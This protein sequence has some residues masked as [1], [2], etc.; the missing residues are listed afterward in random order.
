ME[1]N[2]TDVCRLTSCM[3]ITDEKRSKRGGGG[4]EDGMYIGG[5]VLFLR[6]LL[7]LIPIGE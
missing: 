1:R 5:D 2:A 3:N 6:K 7:L 4:W